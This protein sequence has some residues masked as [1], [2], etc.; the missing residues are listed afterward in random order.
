MTKLLVVAQQQGSATRLSEHRIQI[1]IAINVCVCR[2][3]T[4]QRLEQILARVGSIH[5]SEGCTALRASVPEE[6]RGL[7][8]ALALLQFHNFLVEMAVDRKQI[9]PPVEVV[10]EEKD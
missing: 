10:V 2:G 1:A 8:I 5:G 4:H 3:A 6:L 9:Q 7:A